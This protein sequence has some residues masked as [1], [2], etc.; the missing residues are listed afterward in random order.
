MVITPNLYEDVVLTPEEQQEALRVARE[1]KHQLTLRREYMERLKHDTVWSKPNAREMYEALKM[2]KSKMGEPYQVT[3]HNEAIIFAL[4]LYFTNDPNLEQEFPAFSRK[5]GI[6]LSGN[7]GTG[8]T[9]LMNFFCNNPYAGYS[10]PTCKDISEKF[11]TNWVYE[12]RNAIDYFSAIKKA[13]KPTPYNH[14]VLGFCFGDLG[15]EE[16]KNVYGNK[17]NVIEEI[18]FNRYENNVPFHLTHFTTNLN[19]DEIEARYGVRFRDR[20]KESCNW[21]VLNGPS[22]R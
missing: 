18:F 5:K 11:R 15:T 3:E 13:P 19:A 17:M 14:E 1:A 8:K 21:M 9:H 22:F 10:I 12:D 2:T 20:L 4:C 6:I 7:K 16:D